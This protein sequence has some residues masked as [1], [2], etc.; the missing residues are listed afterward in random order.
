M[1]QQEEVVEVEVGAVDLDLEEVEAVVVAA[2]AVVAVVE[3]GS[4]MGRKL[5][6]RTIKTKV[7]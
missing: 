5:T 4:Q 2:A 3:E 7:N 1:L 6:R